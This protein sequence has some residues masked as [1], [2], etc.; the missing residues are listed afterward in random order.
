MESGCTADKDTADTGRV[1]GQ[2]L[3]EGDE[4]EVEGRRGEGGS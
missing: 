3:F 4:G 2:S 1:T